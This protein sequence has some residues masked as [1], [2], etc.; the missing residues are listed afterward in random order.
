[1]LAAAVVAVVL[2]RKRAVYSLYRA[3]FCIHPSY[4]NTPPC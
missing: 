1:M 3:H 4:C 2:V